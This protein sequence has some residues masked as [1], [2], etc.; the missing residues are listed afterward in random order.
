MRDLDLLSINEIYG[1]DQYFLWI[2]F[3]YIFVFLIFLIYW[4][5][6]SAVF[7]VTAFLSQKLRL[8]EN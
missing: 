1:R 4:C 3:S 6:I 2:Y 7:I 8:A 5:L